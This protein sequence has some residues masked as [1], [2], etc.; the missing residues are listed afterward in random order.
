MGS[1]KQFLLVFWS[2]ICFSAFADVLSESELAPYLEDKSVAVFNLDEQYGE[3]NQAKLIESYS[4]VY[5]QKNLKNFVCKGIYSFNCR[6]NIA[7]IKQYTNL[8]LDIESALVESRLQQV[9][10]YKINYTTPG[11]DAKAITVSGAV[12]LPQSTQK[13]KGIV[14]FYHFT[15]LN[16]NNVP[17]RF[18]SDF[19]RVSYI[20]AASFASAGY[21]VVLPD[22]VGQGDDKEH[23]H[24]YLLHPEINAMS[25]LYMLKALF[26]L[27]PQLRFAYNSNSRIKVVLTGYSEGSGYA[28]WA[29]KIAQDNPK[30]LNQLGLEITQ[31]ILVSGVY[32]LSKVQLAALQSNLQDEQKAPYFTNNSFMT[33]VIRPA[34]VVDLLNSY[35]AYNNNES[36]GLLLNPVFLNCSDCYRQDKT[37]LDVLQVMQSES[38]GD[39]AKFKSIYSAAKETEYSSSNNSVAGLVNPNLFSNSN[40]IKQLDAAN[41]YNWQAKTPITLFSYVNDSVVTSLDTQSTYLALK[42]QNSVNVKMRL[43]DN[44]DFKAPSILPFWDGSIDHP[45]GFTVMTL[46]VRSEIL[47]QD[48]NDE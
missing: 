39:I 29:T 4:P 33:S 19:F 41:I 8:N 37:H 38:F 47:N 3:L 5:F 42:K 44:Q 23:T 25:G 17:S 11:V 9:N 36:A 40:F 13:L 6:K 1:C 12:L 14:V 48:K 35:L 18:E 43:I 24:P 10:A 30:Y 20:A 26:Q 31:S 46:L 34:L 16:N 22:Y 15:A 2:L 7:A 21:V 28:L 27:E 32:N 45:T